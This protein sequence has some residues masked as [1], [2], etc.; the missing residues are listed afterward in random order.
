MRSLPPRLDLEEW[1]D[2]GVFAARGDEESGEITLD[3]QLG[4]RAKGNRKGSRLMRV[5]PQMD[6]DTGSK[7]LFIGDLLFYLFG[8][9]KET[10]SHQ[11]RCHLD[12]K[13]SSPG[14]SHSCPVVP[15]TRVGRL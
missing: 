4:A 3:E 10:L 9:Q 14:T 8:G 5:T 7:T 1:R 12:C 11:T 2:V 13:A 6:G 15:W